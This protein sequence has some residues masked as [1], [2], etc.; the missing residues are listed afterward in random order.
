MRLN[1]DTQYVQ[2]PAESSSFSVS[3]TS[4]DTCNNLNKKKYIYGVIY[5]KQDRES[6]WYF[7]TWR[8]ITWPKEVVKKGK[9]TLQDVDLF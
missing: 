3:A 4:L 1:A 5:Q 6:E 8:S 9:R 2:T 7:S